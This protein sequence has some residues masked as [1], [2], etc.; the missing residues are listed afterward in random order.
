MSQRW[1][2]EPE[3]AVR[4]DRDLGLLGVLMEPTTV[5]AKAW[6]QIIKIGTGSVADLGLRPDIV[7]ECTGVGELILQATHAAAAGGIVCL[8]GVGSPDSA[9]AGPSTATALAT[10]AVLKNLV[11]FGS[12]NANRRHYDRAAQAL[13]RADRSWLAPG[14]GGRHRPRVNRRRVSFGVSG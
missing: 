8:T 1:R 2:I 6:E 10:E 3:Y 7:V 13:A 4:V 11:V 9:G 5:V 14:R 12:V